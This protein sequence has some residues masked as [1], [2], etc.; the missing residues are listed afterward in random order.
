[1]FQLLD[2]LKKLYYFAKCLN[3][4]HDLEQALKLGFYIRS[5]LFIQETLILSCICRILFDSTG[6]KAE[7]YLTSGCEKIDRNQKGCSIVLRNGG[8]WGLKR[9]MN[10]FDGEI[11]NTSPLFERSVV[12]LHPIAAWSV[13][14]VYKIDRLPDFYLFI[15]SNPNQIPW[16]SWPPNAPGSSR[17]NFTTI[18]LGSCGQPDRTTKTKPVH[19]F[20]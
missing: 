14:I 19:L 12:M 10:D 17:L 15:S 5:N 11:S 6:V 9:V 13:C 8:I 16:I 3:L 18:P 7:G 2:I 1:M 4:K 20:Y